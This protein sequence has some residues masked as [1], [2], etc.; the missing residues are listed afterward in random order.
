MTALWARELARTPTR[1][2]ATVHTNLSQVVSH[3][4]SLKV[5]LVPFFAVDPSI[6]RMLLWLFRVASLTTSHTMR[7]DAAT[8]L[9]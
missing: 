1:I 6:G 9:E 3:A 8:E 4:P 7:Q 5:R 2:I